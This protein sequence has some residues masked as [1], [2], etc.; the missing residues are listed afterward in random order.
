MMTYNYIIITTL[1]KGRGR[2]EFDIFLSIATRK[3]LNRNPQEEI[4]KTFDLFDVDKKGK[5][6]IDNLKIIAENLGEEL[7]EDE[8]KAMIEEFDRDLDGEL[9]FNE[10]RYIMTQAF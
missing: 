7:P 5:I 10:F 4:L 2:V 3:I 1:I 8:I 6:S 9:N